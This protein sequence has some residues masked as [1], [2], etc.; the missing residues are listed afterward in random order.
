MKSMRAGKYLK[1]IGHKKALCIADNFICMDKE[2][3]EGFS[4]AF[5]PGEIL[6]WEIPKTEEERMIFYKDKYQTLLEK[7][8]LLFLQYQISMHLNLCVFYRVRVFRFPRI[9]R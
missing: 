6:R 2:R 9:S 1:E 3:I 8:L 5:E 7:K 4:E